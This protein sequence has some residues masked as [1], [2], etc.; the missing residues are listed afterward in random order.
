MLS[1][2]QAVL[3]SREILLEVGLDTQYLLAR[4]RT[5][6]QTTEATQYE[7]QKLRTRDLHF[8]SVQVPPAPPPQAA[9]PKA[10]S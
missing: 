7:E 3:E 8:L 1:A 2:P 10:A 6:G 5:L 4:M 9:C